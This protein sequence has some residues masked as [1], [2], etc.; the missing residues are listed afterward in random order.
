MKKS[1]YGT[2]GAPF[3]LSTALVLGAG[4]VWQAKHSFDWTWQG[5]FISCLFSWGVL[6]MALGMFAQAVLALAEMLFRRSISLGAVAAVILIGLIYVVLGLAAFRL[7]Y[8]WRGIITIPAVLSIIILWIVT[9]RRARRG[10]N[11]DSHA[12]SEPA[13]GAD[14]SSHGV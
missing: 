11:Q 6:G 2:I 4:T 5:L 13:P 1:R 7:P 3:W 14:S 12:T 10:H 9:A 8:E